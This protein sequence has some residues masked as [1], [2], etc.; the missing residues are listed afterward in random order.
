MSQDIIICAYNCGG[1]VDCNALAKQF[2]EPP[3]VIWIPGNSSSDFSAYANKYNSGQSIL[4][5]MLKA[6]APKITPRRV[7]LMSFSAGWAH[8]TAIVNKEGDRKRIDSIVV[9]DGIHT[10][11]LDGWSAFADLSGV[12]GVNA[13]NLWMA[14]TQIKPPYVS[15]KETNT[16]IFKGAFDKFAATSILRP[17][18][19]YIIGAEL[20]EPITIT[21]SIV[22]PKQKNYT[23][24]TLAAFET[25]GNVGRFEY[26]GQL[27]QDHIYNAHY[28]QPRFWHWLREVWSDPTAGVHYE[29]N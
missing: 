15:T 16:K 7:C 6:H 22:T 9:Y 27:P 20:E 2:A 11:A 1:P 13:P 24:D 23:K 14:H 18:P 10:Q 25:V 19:S 17:I 28:V 8:S 12:G 4:T 21:S 26:S 3:L 5:N 29:N